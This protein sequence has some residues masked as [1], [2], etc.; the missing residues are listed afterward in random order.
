ML[1]AEV[2]ALKA[3][4]GPKAFAAHRQV[5]LFAALVR[6]VHETVPRNPDAVGFRQGLTLGEKFT[7]WRRVK[8]HGLPARWRLFFKFSDKSKVIVFVWLND[9]TTLR[10]AGA[11]TD[12]YAVF[13]KMLQGGNPPT[14]L[15]SLQKRASRGK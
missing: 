10:Q 3:E 6:I 2:K 15:A 11:A 9:E 1:R 7:S 8:G 5:K 13:R 4:L 14:D 12:V